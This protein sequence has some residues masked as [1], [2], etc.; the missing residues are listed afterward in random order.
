MTSALAFFSANPLTV[1]AAM[2]IAFAVALA[3]EDWRHYRS[4]MDEE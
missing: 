1:L 3:I 2:V 4:Y